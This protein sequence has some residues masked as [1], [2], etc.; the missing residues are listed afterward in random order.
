MSNHTDFI[1]S[2]V[3]SINCK[4]YL[5]LGLYV[6]ETFEKV[7]PFVSLCCGVDIKDLRKNKSIGNFFQMNTVN[8]FNQNTKMFDV[9]FIDADHK[10]ESVL[11]D[12]EN[13]LKFLNKNGVIIMHDTDPTEKKWLD[14]GYCGDAYRI[15]NYVHNIHPDL[16]IMTFPI[17]HEGLTLVKR[18]TDL[19]VLEAK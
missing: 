9:I 6:G 13:S 4:S 2:L 11:I 16:D 5:E 18:K 1:V 17:G 3:R 10:Y 7:A 19:R 8:F 15:I 12:L 14:F